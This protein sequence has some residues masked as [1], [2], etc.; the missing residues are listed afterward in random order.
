[1]RAH[2]Q[3]R[4]RTAIVEADPP[5]GACR[6]RAEAIEL[7]LQ[8]R[9]EALEEVQAQLS[10]LLEARGI[11]PDQAVNVGVAVRESVVNAIRHG[12]AL[13][14]RK[15][16]HVCLAVHNDVLDVMVADEG[17][18][19]DP[20]SLPDPFAPENLLKPDGRGMLMM[21]SFMDDVAFDFPRAGGTVVRMRKRLA[22]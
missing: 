10:R 1:M 19:F 17:E 7:D 21:R 18:G 3:R 22:G 16:V 12:N 13:D 14:P 5:A 15:H 6:E 11:D 4:G 9:L 2:A 8:S 20:G